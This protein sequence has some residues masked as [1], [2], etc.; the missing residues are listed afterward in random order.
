MRIADTVP[1]F[2][3]YCHI[4]KKLSQHTIKAYD[5][6][7][8]TLTSSSTLT[9]DLYSEFLSNTIHNWLTNSDLKPA[10]IKRRIAT[11]K[12][13]SRWLVKTKYI[14]TY[15][16]DALSITVK[17]PRRLP[18]NLRTS[19]MK[20]L[21]AFS[22]EKNSEEKTEDREI[23]TSRKEWDR[24]TAKLSIEIMTLTGIR[25]GELTRVTPLDVDHA[26]RRINIQGKGNRERRVFFPDQV[27]SARIRRYSENAKRRFGSCEERALLVNGLGR[28]ASEQYLRRIIRAYATEM[29]VERRVTPHMLRHT[30]ATQLLE[31]GLDI[32]LVQKLLGHASITTTEIYTHV[33]DY[34]LHQKIA[35]V[36]I[37]KR[38][39]NNR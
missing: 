18:R 11:L 34:H 25:V 29:K 14:R 28:D 8:R 36:N 3:G 10:T 2:L 4:T 26:G 12:V 1:L 5:G 32:R 13:F 39:E 33:A 19:E 35:K 15:P 7:L 17:L 37:R 6:D 24:A 16:D 31:A 20:R 38:L 23:L 30:A 22:S 27:T 21:A 9:D